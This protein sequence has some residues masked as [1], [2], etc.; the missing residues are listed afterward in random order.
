MQKN[1]SFKTIKLIPI[2]NSRGIRVPKNL[3]AKYGFSETL[4]LEEREEGIL[5]K[6]AHPDKLS[7]EETFNQMA[8]EK[9]DWNDFEN[10]TSDGLENLEWDANEDWD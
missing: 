9:E 5:L 4:I 7:W 2:G 6:N 8:I 1:T 3:I 10:T